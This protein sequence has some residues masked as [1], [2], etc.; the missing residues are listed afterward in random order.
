MSL[1]TATIS[2]PATHTDVSKSNCERV[3][4]PSLTLCISV[5]SSATGNINSEKPMGVILV[6]QLALKISLLI[7]WTVETFHVLLY[8]LPIR[9]APT[10]RLRLDN[11]VLNTIIGLKAYVRNPSKKD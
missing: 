3:K 10:R 11:D 6:V 5:L 2:T 4:L 8:L 7:S 9:N 1:R